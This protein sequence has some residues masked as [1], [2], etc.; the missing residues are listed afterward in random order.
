MDLK[1]LENKV[2]IITNKLRVGKFDEVIRDSKLLIKKFSDQQILYNIL[3][4]AYQQKGENDKSIDLLTS[5]LKKSPK[6]IFFLN[7]MGASHYNKKNLVEAEYYF[8][9]ALEI[10]PNYINAL[11]NLG[12]LKKDLD[13]VDEA[14]NFYKKSIKLNDNVM[15]THFNLGVL[16]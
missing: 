1:E 3:S 6:N 10:N 15:E 5:A 16:Y 2:N 14:K 13:L 9:R 4:L 7:N 12:N 8:E 11:N